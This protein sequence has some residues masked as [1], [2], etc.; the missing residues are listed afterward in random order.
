V[1]A[2]PKCNT[3]APNAAWSKRFRASSATPKLVRGQ[4]LRWTLS[5]ANLSRQMHCLLNVMT[6]IDK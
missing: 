4:K 6:F 1:T 3:K 5:E 2:A